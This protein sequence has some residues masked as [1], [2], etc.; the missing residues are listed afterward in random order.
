MEI[1]YLGDLQA[2]AVRA[3]WDTLTDGT[4]ILFG[5]HPEFDA[6]A[7]DGSRM[8]RLKA[9]GKTWRELHQSLREA[10]DDWRMVFPD[11]PLPAPNSD[12]TVTR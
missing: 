8:R 4:P 9:Q 7:P 6:V 10:V 3:E 2:Y 11:E 1:R 12:R 5:W